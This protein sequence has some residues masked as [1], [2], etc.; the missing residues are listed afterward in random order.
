[1]IPSKAESPAQPVRVPGGVG[2]RFRVRVSLVVSMPASCGTDRMLHLVWR[3]CRVAH[4]L[5]STMLR[6]CRCLSAARCSPHTKC[7]GAVCFLVASR[8][9]SRPLACRLLSVARCLLHA[10]PVFCAVSAACCLVAL[11]PCWQRCLVSMVF[12]TLSAVCCVLHGARCMLHAACLRCMSLLSAAC[13]LKPG[14]WC[15][16][17]LRGACRLLFSA[18]CTL[19]AACRPAVDRCTLRVVSCIF[20]VADCIRLL[21]FPRCMLHVVD[22]LLR[23]FQWSS[24]AR[25][26]LDRV[27]L[28][29]LCCMLHV[30]PRLWSVSC[31]R[32]TVPSRKA[33]LSVARPA[34]H[35]VTLDVLRCASSVACCTLHAVRACVRLHACVRVVSE[36]DGVFVGWLCVRREDLCEGN[37]INAETA[38]ACLRS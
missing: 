7:G 31:A 35:L 23:I 16:C 5:S 29:F 4:W 24:A 21:H 1:M 19:H 17:L 26:P 28:P 3:L 6:A 14:A 22:G 37:R 18:Y 34:S 15:L 12:S 38:A 25:C 13:C 27:C 20:P 11:L 32:P 33:V 10:L 9:C 30:L 2:F 36:R 8:M